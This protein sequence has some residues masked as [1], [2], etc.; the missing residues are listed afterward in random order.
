MNR[1]PE[2]IQKQILHLLQDLLPTVSRRDAEEVHQALNHDAMLNSAHSSDSQTPPTSS[3]VGNSG[4]ERSLYRES[5]FKLGELPAVQDRFHAL[6]KN[7]LQSE[8]QKNPPLFP[9]ETEGYDYE[10][11]YAGATIA[12][13]VALPDRGA[14]PAWVW[15]RHL[16]NLHLPVALPETVVAQ[17]LNRCQTVV[18]STLREGAKLVQAVEEFFPEQSQSLNYLAGLVMTSPARSGSATA[19]P[20]IG[21]DFPATFEQAALPQ[22]MV[23]SLLAAREIL[24]SLTVSV[25]R[26]QPIVEREWMTD[27]GMLSLRAVYSWDANFTSVRIQVNL[28]SGGSLVLQGPEAQ[29]IAQ[30][31][32]TGYLSVEL[33]EPQIDQPYALDVQLAAHEQ[34]PLTFV[35]RVEP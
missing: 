20:A 19:M 33:F 4:L 10:A 32:N 5:L 18:R 28:P 31:P 24:T 21:A 23:L 30:R 35:V 26:S 8:I 27:L 29:A 13:D 1:D 17:L 34:A 16:E 3:T 15:M 7:R 25:S 22:Q 9:W 2:D 12:D 6:L 14:V 11:I